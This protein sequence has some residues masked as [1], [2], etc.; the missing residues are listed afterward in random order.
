MVDR[1]VISAWRKKKEIAAPSAVFGELE[2][3]E[4]S[5]E[6]A[7]ERIWHEEHVRCSLERI[8]KDVQPQTLEVYRK[9][10]FEGWSIEEVCSA[11][12]ISKTNASVIKSRMTK[13]LRAEMDA[14]LNPND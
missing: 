4:E 10:A 3:R 8:A 7:F 13:R 11:F 1:L 6:N 12:G 9:L 14:I 5:P 2:G